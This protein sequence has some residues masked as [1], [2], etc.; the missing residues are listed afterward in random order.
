M[1]SIFLA[2][3]FYL[4]SF[5]SILAVKN[6]QPSS[7]E[8]IEKEAFLAETEKQLTVATSKIRKD[9]SKLSDEKLK[10]RYGDL[11]YNIVLSPLY[12]NEL[13]F[14]KELSFRENLN[15]LTSQH[16]IDF[17]I[18]RIAISLANFKSVEDFKEKQKAINQKILER[19]NKKG[20]LATIERAINV[21]VYIYGALLGFVLLSWVISFVVCEDVFAE[22]MDIYAIFR[23]CKSKD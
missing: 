19:A 12:Q 23:F 15:L 9:L 1:K 13:G 4:T 20:T 3:C 11:V 17:Q 16:F 21:G 6:I 10:R 22:E 5:N 7:N 2:L 14:S 18:D 8:S